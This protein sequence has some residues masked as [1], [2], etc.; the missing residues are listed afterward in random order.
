MCG[1]VGA[2]SPAGA[3]RDSVVVSAL[4]TLR[5]RGPDDEG[6]AFVRL[7]GGSMECYGGPDSPRTLPLPR[8]QVS[9]RSTSVM[10]LGF[11]R[12]SILDLSDAGHQPMSDSGGKMWL[13]LNGEIYNYVEL[14]RE[15]ERAG[16]R[17]RTET[18]TEV[19]LSAWQTWGESALS[20]IRGMFAFAVVDLDKRTATLV[21]DP[22]GIKPFYWTCQNGVFAFASEIKALFKFPGVMPRADAEELYRF[23][24]FGATEVDERSCFAGIEQVL[25]GHS[26]SVDLDTGQIEKS[27]LYWRYELSAPSAGSTDDS[28]TRLSEIMR[29]AVRLHM[30][31]DVPVGSC[32]SGGLDS[33]LIVALAKSERPS[34]SL[35]GICFDNGLGEGSDAPYAVTTGKALGVN[36]E[37]VN[38]SAEDFTAD[39]GDLIYHQDVPFE[40]TSIY[41]Q[42]AVFR[43]A[44]ECGITVMLDGQGA[45]ELFGG[46]RT[47]ISARICEA[48]WHG[49]LIA[50]ARLANSSAY[51]DSASHRR[52]LLAAL[53]RVAPATLTAPLLRL[54][55]EPLVS[56]EMNAD[57]FRKHGVE[58]RRR[59]EGRGRSALREE[60]AIQVRAW[61]LPHLL[62]YEDRSSMAFSIEARVPFC[63][64]EVANFAST[65]S[66]DQLI[67]SRGET[68][69]VLRAAAARSV[70]RT[71]LERPKLGFNTNQS[72]W[73]N[74][75]SRL[76]RQ[77]LSDE[78]FDSVKALDP[79][80]VRQR[81]LSDLERGLPITQPMWRVL[82]VALWSARF[83]VSYT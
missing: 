78:R 60:L 75:A 62:R 77:I 25:P 51:P 33:S 70:P 19:L 64:P 14:R 52:M 29:E 21:R 10:A 74:N 71:V 53:G 57:W 15:L 34:A 65:L 2:I 7:P 44:R 82:V 16:R 32:F 40:S 13:A 66:A 36:V 1:I 4:N 18:D 6:Y 69:A 5:H 81:M 48:L 22:F 49:D 8:L 39:L 28:P 56:P 68:K 35:T 73:L 63:T 46:Y 30:R 61:S 42:Y 76:F 26:M 83:G 17:F 72:L 37:V 12:L 79:R 50:V 58:P 24:R 43:R 3:I 9:E 67:S 41:A 59:P 45:D 27:K 47:S 80:A 38:P 55:G 23:L 54:I 20:R 31:S 11:R